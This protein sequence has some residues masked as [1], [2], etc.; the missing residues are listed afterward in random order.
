M[1]YTALD[2]VVRLT[3]DVS[4]HARDDADV[5]IRMLRTYDP[6]QQ[7]VVTVAVDGRNPVTV[8]MKLHRPS[9]VDEADGVH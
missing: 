3:T 8:K 7:A 6:T 2:E 9:L 1:T 4:E 5:L